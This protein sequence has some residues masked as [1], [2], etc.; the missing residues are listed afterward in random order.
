MP[1]K[2]QFKNYD[3][4]KRLEMHVIWWKVRRTLRVYSM[5]G[6][7]KNLWKRDK[8]VGDFWPCPHYK[9]L[10]RPGR[11]RNHRHKEWFLQRKLCEANWINHRRNFMNRD[12]G[13]YTYQ[14]Y[15]VS[16][17]S[18]WDTYFLKI[19]AG[20]L[21]AQLKSGVVAK[22]V[23]QLSDGCLSL[24]VTITIDR[25]YSFILIILGCN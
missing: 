18:T 24:S 6:T 10:D 9:S 13:S 12:E 23:L 7:N 19:A 25:I 8:Q 22:E 15:T 14:H 16:A 5:S 1:L 3:Q 20:E 4:I 21:S 11:I 17:T 2:N